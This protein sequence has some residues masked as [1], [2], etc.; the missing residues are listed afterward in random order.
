M[1]DTELLLIG[2]AII[3]LICTLYLTSL[4]VVVWKK[5]DLVYDIIKRKNSW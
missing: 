4:I 5:L 1:S 2:F 3:Q